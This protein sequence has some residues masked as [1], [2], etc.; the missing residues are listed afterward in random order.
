MPL[1]DSGSPA[2]P[3]QL[4]NEDTKKQRPKTTNKAIGFLRY[5]RDSDVGYPFPSADDSESQAR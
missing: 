4:V 1:N 2:L 3:L 5:N